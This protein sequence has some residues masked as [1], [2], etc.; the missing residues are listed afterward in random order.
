MTDTQQ[1]LAV[2]DLPFK[3]WKELKDRARASLTN[4]HEPGG[5]EMS[6][7]SADGRSVGYVMCKCSEDAHMIYRKT[8]SHLFYSL[9]N[10]DQMEC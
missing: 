6:Q 2:H 3:T 5:T 7:A 10:P 4:G 8:A 9:A 1:R